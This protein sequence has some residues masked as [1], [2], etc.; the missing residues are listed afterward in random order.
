MDPIHIEAPP[1][2]RPLSP[3]LENVAIKELNENPA[4]LAEDLLILRRWIWSQPHLKARTNDQFL[5]AFLRGSKF[6]LER[7]KQKIDRYYT[8][9]A[10]IPEVFNEQRQS[11]DPLVLEIVRMGVILQIPLPPDE[12]RPCVTIIR[13][14]AYDI[15]KYKFADIIRVGS[16]FGEIMMIEDDNSTVCGYLEIMDMIGV[17][18]SHLFHLPP[19]LV[20][21]FSIFADEAMPMRQKGTCFINVPLS[22]E[23]GFNTM[24]AFFPEKMK[25][26]I[27]VS[28][29][30]DVIY[31]FVPAA[32]L[33]EEYGG[34]NGTI[35]DI[36]KRM[37][38]K[39]LKYR[40]YFL[41]ERHYGTEEKL[42]ECNVKYDYESHFGIEG[43]FRKLDID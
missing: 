31:D 41:N 23:K 22:F 37:E 43:S 8:L 36:I 30:I 34:T 25:N 6:S 7:A 26:R 33:P 24:K 29:S 21:K 11:D 13:S 18:G 15:N 2:I 17:T 14:T 20:R 1:V 3:A 12:S 5:L 4:R 38:T 27:T 19:D 10:A 42:R 16:M 39:L 9:K 40:D 32:Y 35:N 28:S